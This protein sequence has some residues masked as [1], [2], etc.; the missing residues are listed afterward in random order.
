MCI[1]SFI[2]YLTCP[3]PCILNWCA[4]M[5]NKF[6]LKRSGTIRTRGNSKE[7][8]I[9]QIKQRRRPRRRHQRPRS[10]ITTRK[11]I[12]RFLSQFIFSSHSNLYLQITHKYR[13]R[14]N[15]WVFDKF[16]RKK[17]YNM[18]KNT[19]TFLTSHPPSNWFASRDPNFRTI[20]IRTINIRTIGWLVSNSLYSNNRP[21]PTFNWSM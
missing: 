12:F 14:T 5:V 13:E 20:S 16:W 9:G 8:N 2:N 7:S 17:N 10:D 11:I 15:S 1:L 4:S 19:E 21:S 6:C 18:K 3:Q